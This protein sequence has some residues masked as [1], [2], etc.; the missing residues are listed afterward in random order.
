MRKFGLFGAIVVALILGIVVMNH[1]RKTGATTEDAAMSA[2]AMGSSRRISTRIS[3]VPFVGCN[4]DG[5]GG[6]VKAPTGESKFVHVDVK[7]AQRLA[8][9]ES[10]KEFGVLAPRGWYCFGSYGADGD[11][12]YVSPRPINASNLFSSISRGFTGPM[13]QLSRSVADTSGRFSVAKTIARVFPKHKVFVRKVIEEGIEP[14]S[15]FPFGPYPGDE[16]TYKSDEI[17]EYQTPAQTE[18]LG[19]DSLLLKDDKSISGVA[20]L[21]GQDSDLLHLSVRLPQAQI[22]LTASIVQQVER[23]VADQSQGAPSVATTNQVDASVP[24]PVPSKAPKGFPVPEQAF[25]NAYVL[26]NIG[27]E[28]LDQDQLVQLAHDEYEMAKQMD[29]QTVLLGGE[30]LDTRGKRAMDYLNK[31]YRQQQATQ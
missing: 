27:R 16:L 11:T 29:T 13:I 9:Y 7:A 6:P 14:A 25:V 20:I 8:Y 5:Q 21:T 4:S 24:L 28:D 1:A 19:T 31:F 30:F 10:E 2:P 3:R 15:S 22:G 23:D 17:V 12:L 26:A 18:G